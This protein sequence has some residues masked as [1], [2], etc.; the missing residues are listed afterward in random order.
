MKRRA[1]L[2]LT[3]MATA[4]LLACTVAL[5]AD[6]PDYQAQVVGGTPVPNG[7]YPFVAALL[8]ARYPGEPR[9]QQFCGG[10]LIDQDSVLTAAHCVKGRSAAPLRVI[11]GRTVLSSDRGQKRSVLKIFVHQR[12]SSNATAYDAA[13][14]KLSSSVSGTAPI[15]VATAAQNYLE[16]PGRLATVAGWGNTIKQP[17]NDH[18]G[19]RFP[20]RMREARVPLVS[21]FR[22]EE[23]YDAVLGPAGY[24][25]PIM[26]AAGRKGNDAC[27]GDSGGPL[28]ARASGGY[29]QIGIVSFGLG[30]GARGYPGVYAEVNAPSI[31]SFVSVAAR[32]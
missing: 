19:S 10:T 8:D 17:P 31:R 14:L 18:N 22:A 24:I 3:T 28:F 9:N 26:V 1:I 5:A 20:N 2:S 27:N 21:D 13:V 6:D 32:R 4:L 25:P 16:R 30:C 11:V 15:R 7:K 23:P 29:T 12:Y